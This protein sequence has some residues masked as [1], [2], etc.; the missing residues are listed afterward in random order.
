MDSSEPNKPAPDIVET[1]DE[2]KR[3]YQKFVPH[4]DMNHKYIYV[5]KDVDLDALL[6]WHMPSE[7]IDT[8]SLN[9]GKRISR[10]QFLSSLTDDT[11]VFKADE[12]EIVEDVKGIDDVILTDGC[13][14]ISN[15]A[16]QI[17][18][19]ILRNTH[20][21]E[22]AEPIN[23]V[24]ARIGPCKG[25]FVVDRSLAGIQ[26]KI[27]L[28]QAKYL[29]DKNRWD[30]IKRTLEICH[31][32]IVDSS[33]SRNGRLNCQIITLLEFHC[34]SEVIDPLVKLQI[35]QVE[36]I[37]EDLFD[38]ESMEKPFRQTD[39]LRRRRTTF[40]ALEP[41][42]KKR[43]VCADLPME[44]ENDN[45][46]Q[47]L[48]NRLE[49]LRNAGF[50]TNEPERV[51]LGGWYLSKEFDFLTK[52]ACIAVPESS[53]L[54]IVPD[55]SRKLL[56]KQCVL[57]LGPSRR[58]I[59]GKVIVV[60][61]PCFIPSDMEMWEAIDPIAAELDINYATNL[62]VCPAH[63]QLEKSAVDALSGGDYDGDTALV[64]WDRS[65]VDLWKN[66]QTAPVPVEHLLEVTPAV[67]ARHT[68]LASFHR[69]ADQVYM[70]YHSSKKNTALLSRLVERCQYHRGCD[71]ESTLRN[72]AFAHLIL[73]SLKQGWS[74]SLFASLTS[75]DRNDETLSGVPWRNPVVNKFDD[76]EGKETAVFILSRRMR[77]LNRMVIQWSIFDPIES[78]AQDS[79]GWG[80]VAKRFH[81]QPPKE[82]DAFLGK[83]YCQEEYQD[84]EREAMR[85]LITEYLSC[86][87]NRTWWS[88]FD[89]EMTAL[90]T[91]YGFSNDKAAPFSS[92]RF[93][94]RRLALLLY[95]ICWDQA[96]A[97][98]RCI[99]TPMNAQPQIPLKW[100]AVKA[101]D[102]VVNLF[103]LPF[104]IASRELVSMK[105]EEK[106]SQIAQSSVMATN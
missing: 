66:K 67:K 56:P 103:R 70:E 59:V 72:G 68:D 20:G 63:S 55:F 64:I 86:K 40:A 9:M 49:D 35:K 89:E 54:K 10:M 92:T 46:R 93:P 41:Q 90:R 19:R 30:S 7:D 101:T 3:K 97:R 106:S 81:C 50:N 94:N 33:E 22:I 25:M 69:G 51:R 42:P 24:Q 16:M 6:Q 48:I 75:I 21:R 98:V 45:S 96:M 57:A 62:L 65:I 47:E 102:D 61:N 79:D 31:Q 99:P 60:R 4:H 91:K 8:K 52:K 95:V 27:S 32:G 15:S 18:I 44:E 71:H 87:R 26:I 36:A 74:P 58:L 53:S 34:G 2:P 77:S 43:R 39:A 12:I 80:S 100:S 17:V 105:R 1:L 28:S 14:R 82:Y 84:S 88:H 104:S 23:A 37:M 85:N 38:K 83:F 73:D 5:E 78:Y 13:G 11:L 76:F 29:K